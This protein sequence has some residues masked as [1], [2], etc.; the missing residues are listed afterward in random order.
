MTMRSGM[1]IPFF[2]ACPATQG[3]AGLFIANPSGSILFVGSE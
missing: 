1:V 2:P 3:M